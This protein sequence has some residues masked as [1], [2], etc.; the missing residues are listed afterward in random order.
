MARYL[1]TLLGFFGGLMLLTVL[2]NVIID[3]FDIYRV[4]ELPGIVKTE[5][6][7]DSSS[8]VSVSFEILRGDYDAVFIGNSRVQQTITDGMLGD[9]QT[10]LNAGMP[11]LNAYEL[12]R[13]IR[14]VPANGRVRCVFVGLESEMFSTLGSGK[15]T[16]WI[17]ALPDAA[18][19]WARLRVSVAYA[20][21]V[22]GWR[23]LVA[24]I[25]GKTAPHG[26]TPLDPHEQHEKFVTT[27]RRSYATFRSYEYDPKRV[28]LVSRAIAQA[29]A[30]GVQVIGYFSPVHA[31]RD[32][33]SWRSGHGEDM[34]RL[35]KEM[36]AAFNKAAAHKATRQCAQ[37][38][39]AI[40]WDF[41]GY[42]PVSQSPV[43][44]VNASSAPP[45]YREASHYSRLVAQAMVRRMLN[46]PSQLPIELGFGRQLTPAT[47]AD[48]MLAIRERRERWL[49][50]S[51][52]AAEIVRL[53]AQWLKSDAPDPTTDRYY[54][55]R[56]DFE[57]F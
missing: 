8:R 3:P 14:L 20:T 32:E 9:G 44:A 6:N 29:T 11:A 12:A 15:G 48:E 10:V 23:T 39:S 4:V 42:Q 54:L 21:I 55:S 52:D 30:R 50:S 27:A 35:R 51:P 26:L 17:S 37:G 43:P 57:G 2:F 49:A 19:T 46:Q 45:Y 7:N 25:K 1:K 53:T 47:V 31:W 16:Y 38:P 41:G 18:P 36:T 24:N 28:D 56:S 33:V 40:L 34:L 22:H 5:R 13:A